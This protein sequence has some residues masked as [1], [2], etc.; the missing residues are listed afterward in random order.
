[1]E[2]PAGYGGT[3]QSVKPIS[4]I[5]G[6]NRTFFSDRRSPGPRSRGAA[7][8]HPSQPPGRALAQV[9]RALALPM[10]PGGHHFLAGSGKAYIRC[11]CPGQNKPG[12]GRE[13]SA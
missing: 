11:E 4:A 8:N 2:P 3:Q 13:T 7:I 9:S 10:R 12:D 6:S 5:I 1:M